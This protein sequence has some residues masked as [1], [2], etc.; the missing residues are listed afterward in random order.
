MRGQCLNS[1]GNCQFC[2]CRYPQFC[3]VGASGSPGTY[4]FTAQMTLRGGIKGRGWVNCG[5]VGLTF[6]GPTLNSV[7]G[8]SKA[9]CGSGEGSLN[10]WGYQLQNPYETNWTTYKLGGH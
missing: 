5:N 3:N 1:V 6:T 4:S 7:N 2:G 9:T 10:G 8:P